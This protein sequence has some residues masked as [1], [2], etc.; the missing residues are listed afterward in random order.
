MPGNGKWETQPRS[1][2]LTRIQGS[3]FTSAS[4]N[5]KQNIMYSEPCFFLEGTVHGIVWRNRQVQQDNEIL[6]VPRCREILW[7]RLFESF[8][9]SGTDGRKDVESYSTLDSKWKTGNHKANA[10]SALSTMPCTHSPVL[11]QRRLSTCTSL[12]K[13]WTD[14]EGMSVQ[15]NGPYSTLLLKETELL[16]MNLA[17]L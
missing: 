8:L 1:S 7:G 17:W 6:Q 9:M 3:F 11:T 14:N 2:H 15:A 10:M 16:W 5:W 12:G 4:D 13:Q